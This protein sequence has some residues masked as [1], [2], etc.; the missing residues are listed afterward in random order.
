MEN[1][2]KNAM[3]SI[4]D[5]FLMAEQYAGYTT[6]LAV[7]ALAGQSLMIIMRQRG[8]GPHDEDGEDTTWATRDT[9]W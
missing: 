4:I 9:R 6:F 7:L 3:M 5:N 2:W 8:G 1:E